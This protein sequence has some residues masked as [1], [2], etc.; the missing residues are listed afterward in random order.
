VRA[1]LLLWLLCQPL[2]AVS[3]QKPP[4]ST[5]PRIEKEKVGGKPP[6]NRAK[7]LKRPGS[8]SGPPRESPITSTPSP[9]DSSKQQRSYSEPE[10]DWVHKLR[11]DPVATFTALLFFATLALWWAT[12]NLVTGAGD[13]AKRQ[14]RAYLTVPD[15]VGLELPIRPLGIGMAERGVSW[16]VLIENTGQTPAYD[17]SVDIATRVLPYP[18]PP[19]FPPDLTPLPNPSRDVIGPRQSRTLRATYRGTHSDEEW[20]QIRTHEGQ[21]LYVYGIVRYRDAFETRRSIKFC[22]YGVWTDQGGKIIA[23]STEQHNEAD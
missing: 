14:L 18:L 22:A 10:D 2:V 5:K 13:T 21:A 8:D 20:A 6:E 11:T 1:L 15:S 23:C 9:V 12:K 3:Q 19:G 17:S 16:A 4:E 7:T